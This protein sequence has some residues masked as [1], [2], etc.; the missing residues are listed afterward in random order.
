MKRGHRSSID[1][2]DAPVARC[3]T[4]HHLRVFGAVMA[5]LSRPGSAGRP[6]HSPRPWLSLGW[7]G[8][9]GSRFAAMMDI[10]PSATAGPTAKG[11][12]EQ[13][14]VGAAQRRP[15][16]ERSPQS[17]RYFA[18]GNLSYLSVCC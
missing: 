3:P 5:P 11:V 17:R 9:C 10:R 15:E 2:A 12:R 4:P 16:L 8:G 13:R 18:D 6:S 14:A 1:V 7:A